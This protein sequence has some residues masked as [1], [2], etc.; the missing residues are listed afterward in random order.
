MS[1]LPLFASTAGTGSNSALICFLGYVGVVFVIAFL[2]G[3]AGKGKPFVGEYYLGGRNFGMWAF[4]LTYA[5]TLASGGSFMGFP[6]LIYT[7]GWSLA[8]W[9]GGYMVVPLVALGLF[10][11]RINQ[12][13]RIAGAITIPELLRK[14]F[15]SNQVGNVATL[16]VLFFMFF[17]LLAQFKAG[18]EIMATLFGDVPI[19]QKAVAAVERTTGEWFWIGSADADYLVC[20]CC[21]AVAV[22]AYTAYGGFRA[23]VWTDVLQGL[24][25]VIG[26]LILLGLTLSQ[27]GGLEGATRQLALQTPPEFGKAELELIGESRVQTL[28][29]GTFLASA[30]GEVMRLSAIAIMEAKEGPQ[31]PFDVLIITGAE[32]QAQ[33]SDKVEPEIVAHVTERIPYAGGAGEKGVYLSAP[34]PHATKPEG[35]LPVI[36]A[37]SFFGFWT[38]SG[39][40]QPSYMVRQMAF[41]DTIVLRRSILFVAVFFT[42][43]YL[44]LIF[45]FT[46][47]RILLPGMEGEADRI[48]PAM[49]TV[50][51]SNANIPW[52]AG[53]LVAAPFAAIMSSV[54]SFLLLVSSGV[55]R[56]IYQQNTKREVS[57]KTI[58]RLSHWTT[59]SVGALAV[60]C[61]L[62]PPEFLQTLIIFASGGLGASF[63]V[64]VILAL[65]W[66]RMTSRAAVAGMMVGAL[67]MLG[68][69]LKGWSEFGRFSS[70]NPLEIHPF[71]WASLANLLVVVRLSISGQK[72]DR[73]LVERYFGT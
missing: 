13:G 52:L 59:I 16:L 49:A 43:I 5:A 24:V 54:D 27:V 17:F 2:A 23:V 25:M 8:W 69:Y 10:A 38:F 72:P 50:V 15:A 18:A 21:F 22:V 30:D 34:G 31:G 61:A 55:V 68:C 45:I 70:Y 57:E 64:P 33:L 20:L 14:R 11:K 6:A 56:D 3:R 60:L 41:R 65:Y 66:K 1:I 48:M 51:T 26:V 63:L 28:A 44:P 40:G 19:Y 53:I 71:I 7:H 35:F 36:L 73:E 37:L 47:A 42:L 62:N 32:Q 67:V 4:A 46:S 29:K 39:A 9:I 12:V 58:A